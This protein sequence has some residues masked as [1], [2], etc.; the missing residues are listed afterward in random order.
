M[1]MIIIQKIVGIIV[2]LFLDILMI[3][4]GIV[5]VYNVVTQWNEIWILIIALIWFFVP[6]CFGYNMCLFTLNKFIKE[7]II[8]LIKMN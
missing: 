2:L 8:S 5:G 4:G 1:K 7:N 6:F 3:S